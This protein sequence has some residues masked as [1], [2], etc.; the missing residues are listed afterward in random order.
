MVEY[1][2]KG[3]TAC[4]K[5]CAWDVSAADRPIM[6][7]RLGPTASEF[8]RGC[9]WNVTTDGRPCR[10]VGQNRQDLGCANGRP[11][12]CPLPPRGVIRVPGRGYSKPLSR[13]VEIRTDAGPSSAVQC[14]LSG[15]PYTTESQVRQCLEVCPPPPW[16][17]QT[18]WPTRTWFGFE[19]M[20]VGATGWALQS[21]DR[22]Q[23]RPTAHRRA[24]ELREQAQ[25]LHREARS[26]RERATNPTDQD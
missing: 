17:R 18:T 20:T 19:G 9:E 24:T 26:I 3:C 10:L 16:P 25:D 11:R 4:P 13:R 5:T 7:S 6:L 8:H 1:L 22:A 21:A 12:S 14:L 23:R 2:V 15:G